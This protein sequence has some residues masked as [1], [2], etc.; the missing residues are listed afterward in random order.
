MQERHVFGDPA[1][2]AALAGLKRHRA[3]LRRKRGAR[4]RG[5]GGGASRRGRGRGRLVAAIPVVPGEAGAGRDSEGEEDGEEE[6]EAA[7]EDAAD[8]VLDVDVKAKPKVGAKKDSELVY[9]IDNKYVGR[10]GNIYGFA[11]ASLSVACQKHG[12]RKMHLMSA[13]PSIDKIRDW[14]RKGLTVDT[15]AQHEATYYADTG[16]EPPKPKPPKAAKRGRT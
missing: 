1:V 5:R 11:G 16:V 13:V 15:A 10:I 9:S 14:L 3:A 8:V 4:A 7:A 2:A 6:E 12:C